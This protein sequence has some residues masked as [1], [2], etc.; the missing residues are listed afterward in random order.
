MNAALRRHVLRLTF[1]LILPLMIL[2]PNLFWTNF[3]V[4]ASLGGGSTGAVRAYLLAALLPAAYELGDALI[5]RDRSL[6]SLYSVG[7][8]VLSGALAFWFV[9]GFWYAFKTSVDLLLQGLLFLASA[10][11]G[12]ALIKPLAIDGLLQ[13]GAPASR[14]KLE[15]ALRHPGMARAY[16][17]SGLMIG[18]SKLVVGCLRVFVTCH[19]VT[20]AFGTEAF[21]AQVALLCAGF[22]P[23]TL[24][25]GGLTVAPAVLMLERTLKDIHGQEVSL[26]RPEQPAW[27]PAPAT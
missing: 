16:R 1:G 8:G 2:S 26:L 13:Q 17:L 23:L 25:M 18:S 5:R 9:D 24:L 14:Q 12:V 21:N 3:S 10:L 4:A 11:A 19:V 7:T 20:A 6:H 27:Q 22:F 15:E